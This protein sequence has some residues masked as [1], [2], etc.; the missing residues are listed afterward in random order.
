LF[1]WLFYLFYNLFAHLFLCLSLY[2]FAFL[3]KW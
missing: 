2:Y 3:F 1:A